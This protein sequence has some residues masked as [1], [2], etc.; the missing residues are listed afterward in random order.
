MVNCCFS[1][2]VSRIGELHSPRFCQSHFYGEQQ[3]ADVSILEDLST[4]VKC[5]DL[6]VGITDSMNNEK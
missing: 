3:T 2:S 5:T 4:N 6:T 1:T